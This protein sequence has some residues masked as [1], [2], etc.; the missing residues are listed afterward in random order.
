MIPLPCLLAFVCRLRIEPEIKQS[1]IDDVIAQLDAEEFEIRE[2]A[3]SGL[4]AIGTV[5]ESGQPEQ[6]W[7]AALAERKIRSQ[8]LARLAGGKWQTSLGERFLIDG[9]KWSS[10][11][12]LHGPF[13]GR[14]RILKVEPNRWH[15]DLDVK[16][17]PTAGQTVRTILELNDNVLSYCGTYG[18]RPLTLSAGQGRAIYR[19][20]RARQ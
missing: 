4:L 19:F 7:R 18:E 3:V 14:I 5:A 11:T 8:S 10:G 12:K 15:V 20:Q 16:D 2:A 9:E 1:K 17:G 6:R 13:S